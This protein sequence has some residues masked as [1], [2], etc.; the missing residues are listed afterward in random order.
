MNCN[1]ALVSLRR[2]VQAILVAITL[3]QVVLCADEPNGPSSELEAVDFQRDVAPILQAHCV[4]CHGP[5]LQMADLRLD[6]LADAVDG[7]AIE[8]G[9]GDESLLVARLRDDGFGILMPPTGRLPDKDVA[10]L[11]VWINQGADWPEGITLAAPA[12]ANPSDLRMHSIKAALRGGQNDTLRRLV[13][14]SFVTQLT[15][16]DGATPL[17][18][19]ALFGN[20]EA[21]KLLLDAGADPR[22]TTNDGASAL[23]WGAR[24]GEIV[25]R[26]IDRGAD[27]NAKSKVGRTPLIIAA[28]YANNLDA[29][30]ALLAAGADVNAKDDSGTTPLV[31][32]AVT[33]D[34]GLLQALLEAGA[35]LHAGNKNRFSGL[36]LVAAAESN[37]LPAVRLLLKRG[38][39]ESRDA[40]NRSLIAACI[41]GSIELATVL[42]D[43]GADVNAYVT[44]GSTPETPLAAAVYSEYQS[45]SLVELLLERGADVQRKDARDMSPLMIAKQHGDTEIVALLADHRARQAA[46][47]SL[48]LL[49]A[50][51]P[52]FFSKSG[53]VACHQQ[54]ATSLVL[55]LAR[56]RGLAID[57]KTAREQVKLTSMDLGTK[58]GRFLQR[59]HIGGTAHRI[60]YLLLGMAAE[61]YEPDDAT[62]AAVFE[63]A[64]LQ[65]KDG[66]WLSD[67]HRPPSEHSQTSATAISAR[68]MSLF[69]P[70]AMREEI[71]DRVARA[72][73]WLAA[74]EPHANEEHAFR[75]LGLKWLGAEEDTIDA[76]AR[77]IIAQ[78][79]PDGGWSQLPDL[80]SDAYATGLTLYALC[81]G[82]GLNT[83]DAAYER[84]VEFLLNTQHE[85]G[86]WHVVSRSYK[87]Q[88]YFESGFPH[89]H[90]QWISAA[91]TGWAT[92]AILLTLDADGH[93]AE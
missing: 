74:A 3:P 14:D 65:L 24:N 32:A 51:G 69:T 1:F 68:A 50:C 91:G 6:T 44:A 39:G 70:P 13:E 19:A 87:F 38:A 34:L 4:D 71:E 16:K 49:Q 63:L 8:P 66:S 33:R 53:C 89:G 86:S 62:D 73:E 85:D 31:A 76:A 88:P 37:D 23:M 78:Q 55:G 21:V 29:V 61:G 80:E 9:Q 26:L 11:E 36:P 47:K 43:A 60:A 72:R 79:R 54:S 7:G 84:G 2:F 28:S 77:P 46:Q 75:L 83:K 58:R 67:G 82:G 41:H 42:L 92:M 45:A 22:A 30:R 35:D 64:G 81:E 48:S 12:A 57:E 25:D 52:P 56:P 17:L 93:D 15:D 40:L 90:D 10:T 5:A 18:L 59:G 20:T 27:V